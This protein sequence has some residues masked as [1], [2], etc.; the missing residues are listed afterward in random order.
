[1]KELPV[2][3]NIRLKGYDYSNAGYYFV[4]ICVK[5]GHELLWNETPVG[6]HIVR[7]LSDI[8]MVTKKSIENITE[9]Y[10]NVIVDKYTIMP[11]HVHMILRIENGG[12]TMCAPTSHVSNMIKQ[13]KEYVTK[14]IGFS[15]WQRSY[16]DH[17][18]R[19]K[20]EYQKIWK[21]IDQNPTRWT[22]DCYYNKTKGKTT[23]P[24]KPML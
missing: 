1:M 18:I 10:S 8:G 4:T 13:C 11:N 9:I 22:E 16:H 17:I 24:T 21:Y 20:A 15:I 3:K 5:D 6:A 14:Q 2:R 23:N 7:P 19:D 12:R